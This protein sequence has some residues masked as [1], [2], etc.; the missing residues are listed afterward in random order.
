MCGVE[1][2][3]HDIVLERVASH[4]SACADAGGVDAA[5]AAVGDREVLQPCAGGGVEQDAEARVVGDRTS[6]GPHRNIVDAPCD[7][8]AVGRGTAGGTVEVHRG[9]RRRAGGRV[10]P[11]RSERSVAAYGLHEG[12][13]P[14]AGGQREVLGTVKGAAEGEVGIAGER[15]VG[16]EREGAPVGL[17][18]GRGDVAPQRGGWGEEADGGSADGSGDGGRLDCRIDIQVCGERPRA[19]QRELLAGPGAP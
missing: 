3:P 7:G 1:V 4:H 8:Q 2:G 6:D 14:G 5:G 10:D 16:S 9:A 13:R 17:C 12:D 11:Q 18:A 19:R 15:G